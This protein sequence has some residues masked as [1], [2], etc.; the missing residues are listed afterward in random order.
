[1][2]PPRE[3]GTH[4]NRNHTRLDET[5]RQ[6]Q[7]ATSAERIDRLRALSMVPSWRIRGRFRLIRQISFRRF[8]AG[9]RG[10]G[11]EAVTFGDL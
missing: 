3:R 5:T 10:S 1:V 8:L 4:A 7:M 11:E 9:A 6:Q 2:P